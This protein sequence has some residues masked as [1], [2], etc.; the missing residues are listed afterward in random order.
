[1]DQLKAPDVVVAPVRRVVTTKS[2]TGRSRVLFDGHAPKNL[3]VLTELWRSG[4]AG[5]AIDEDASLGSDRLDPP[6]GGSVFRFFEI[7]PASLNAHLSYD[8]KEAAAA[9]WF[10]DMNAAHNRVDTR[11]DPSMHV[12]ATTDYVILLRG[13][14]TLVLDDEEVR[15]KPFDVVVQRQTNH[16]WRNDGAETAL[17]VAVLMDA[18][19]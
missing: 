2:A 13:E 3:T 16:A 11:R 17:L 15:L 19:S 8:E 18:K 6:K 4:V 9:S 7:A 14:I 5:L 1:M 12:S 10:E